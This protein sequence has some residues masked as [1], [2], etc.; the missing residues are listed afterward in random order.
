MRLR[1]D[2]KALL[3]IWD[4]LTTE[5]SRRPE[6]NH[7]GPH[8]LRG[9]LVKNCRLDKPAFFL[10]LFGFCMDYLDMTVVAQRHDSTASPVACPLE[11]MV[12]FKVAV[13]VYPIE[14]G[15]VASSA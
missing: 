4:S 6:T 1:N 13:E 9:E 3:S 11:R 2:L 12:R 8:G 14:A 7:R 15:L 10:R 5:P